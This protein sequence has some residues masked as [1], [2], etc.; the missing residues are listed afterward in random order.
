M[1]N[2]KKES[3]EEQRSGDEAGFIIREEKYIHHDLPIS[4]LRIP[5]P[6]VKPPKPDE[7]SEDSE[8]KEQEE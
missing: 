8:H 5:M 4:S 7:E 3:N 1:S 2:K 6:P